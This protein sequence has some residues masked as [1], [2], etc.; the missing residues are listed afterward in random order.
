MTRTHG[1]ALIGRRVA[2]TEPFNRG[3]HISVIGALGLHGVCAPMTLEGACNSE[4]FDLY[5]EHMLVPNLRPGHMV[6]LDNVKFHYSPRA[7][8]LIESAGASVL[9]I[10]AYSPDFNPI[11]ECI[12][13]IKEALRSFKARTKRKLYNALA[14][15]LAMVTVSDIRGWFE[16]CGYVFSLK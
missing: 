6:L 3:R 1:R 4:V 8:K 13:K 16:H 9:H 7:I 5:V 12:S 11:E 15:V 14:K 2:V 10:P